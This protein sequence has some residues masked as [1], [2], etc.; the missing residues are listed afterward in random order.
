MRR[1]GVACKR[2]GFDCAR[3]GGRGGGSPPRAPSRA[4]WGARRASCLGET[5]LRRRCVECWLK[6]AHHARVVFAPEYFPAIVS[7]PMERVSFVHTDII[8]LVPRD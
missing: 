3:G 1:R 7:R 2:A 6:H 5:L 8:D 4:R